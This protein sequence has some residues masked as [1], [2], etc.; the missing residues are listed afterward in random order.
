MGVSGCLTSG[1]ISS[2]TLVAAHRC[3]LVSVHVSSNSNNSNLIKVW[4]SSDTST[5]GDVEIVRINTS[6]DNSTTA[7]NQEYDM[8]GVNAAEGLYVQI[9]GSGSCAVTITFV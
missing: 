6:A 2:S 4:D 3:K 7:F 5:S 9:T 8:H 1:V